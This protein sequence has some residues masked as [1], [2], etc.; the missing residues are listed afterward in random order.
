MQIQAN[1]GKSK[2]RKLEKRERAATKV[3]ADMLQFMADQGIEYANDSVD[4]TELKE[5]IKS[6]ISKI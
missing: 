3:F 6:E 2:N 5:K 1:P 4:L